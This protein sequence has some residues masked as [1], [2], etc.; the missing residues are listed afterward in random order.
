MKYFLFFIL[1]AMRLSIF[2]QDGYN[3]YAMGNRSMNEG[4]YKQAEEY[5]ISALAKEPTNWNLYTQ[6]GYCYHRQLRF[7][8]ADSLY[9]IAC[10]NDSNNSKPFWYKGLNHVK[11]KQDSMAILCYK[12][13]IAIE[14]SRYGNLTNAYKQIGQAYERILRKDG[15]YSW[16][17]DD[18]IYHYEQIERIEPSTPD[19]PEIRNFIEIVKAKR[20]AN[21]VGKWKLS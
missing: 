8:E 13:F 12:R 5:Y 14:K 7:R 20:P 9:K 16:E 1:F 10:L 18:M 4:N 6:L 3:L 15:L 11:L 2:A 17:I 19:I 21:Q